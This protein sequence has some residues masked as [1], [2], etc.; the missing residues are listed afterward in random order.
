MTWSGH[1]AVLYEPCNT[2]TLN[3]PS[4][5]LM[6]FISFL[7]INHV[8]RTSLLR[9]LRRSRRI[10][11]STSV[12]ILRAGRGPQEKHPARDRKSSH[13]RTDHVAFG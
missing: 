13:L 12:E 9:L 8:P 10:D 1:V 6:M 3:L 4:D 2:P 11:W 5:H 7:C